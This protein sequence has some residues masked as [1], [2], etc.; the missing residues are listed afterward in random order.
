MNKPTKKR[1]STFTTVQVTKA[2]DTKA[3]I[4]NG[5]EASPDDTFNGAY[6]TQG[7][8]SGISPIEPT[9]KPGVLRALT[10][11]HMRSSNSR[12]SGPNT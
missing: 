2:A 6:A 11:H 9:Y 5:V 4:T 10:I 12:R 8:D 1:E 7:S 3:L